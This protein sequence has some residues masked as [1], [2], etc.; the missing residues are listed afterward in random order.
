M[1]SES[2]CPVLNLIFRFAFMVS[3]PPASVAVFAIVVPPGRELHVPSAAAPTKKQNA[4]AAQNVKIMLTKMLHVNA[5]W[6]YWIVRIS[7]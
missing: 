1:P 5:M 4:E 2:V 7:H 3:V 6:T